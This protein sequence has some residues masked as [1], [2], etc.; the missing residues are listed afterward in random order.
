MR[1]QSALFQK[2]PQRN[3]VNL[4]EIHKKIFGKS[5]KQLKSYNILIIK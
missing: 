3:Q 2:A 1:A 5:F 4:N